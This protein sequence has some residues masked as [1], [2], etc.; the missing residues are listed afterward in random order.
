[1]ISET[2]VQEA[3]QAIAGAAPHVV[4]SVPEL[5]DVMSNT[6]SRIRNNADGKGISED[7]NMLAH[8][9]QPIAEFLSLVVAGAGLDEA[10]R[11]T[12]LW[13]V[14]SATVS[15]TKLAS[16]FSA[17]TDS[18]EVWEDMMA[19]L[20]NVEQD[21]LKL[22]WP[23]LSYWKVLGYLLVLAALSGAGTQL[24]SAG[25]S[26]FW[27]LLICTL[28]L[29]SAIVWSINGYNVG[30]HVRIGR[31]RRVQLPDRDPDAVS[32]ASSSLKRENEELRSKL[33]ASLAGQGVQGV[34]AAPPLP[35]PPGVPP[36][37]PGEHQAE[38][39]QAVKE[40]AELSVDAKPFEPKINVEAAQTVVDAPVVV[41]PAVGTEVMLGEIPTMPALNGAV[42]K[43][44][45][46]AGSDPADQKLQIT[47]RSGVVLRGVRPEIIVGLGPFENISAQSSE[48]VYAPY[49]GTPVTQLKAQAGRLR[50]ALVK[51]HGL[52]GSV[53][54]WASYFWQAVDNGNLVYGLATEIKQL[55]QVHGWVGK[56]TVAPPRFDELKKELLSFETCGGPSHGGA[57]RLLEEYGANNIAT[58]EFENPEQM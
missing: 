22:R 58:G 8:C 10:D 56:S 9:S 34:E 44:T 45:E 39:N 16:K 4:L 18:E 6:R 47:L 52:E 42:G 21:E 25:R 43:V 49:A 19:I 46:V 40:N 1:M 14:Y 3:Q 27:C 36:L 50:E 17:V 26:H 54:S 30:G 24:V 11:S 55:M 41:C 2:A 12:L 29:A 23:W 33:E 15:R 53:S 35:P 48:Q 38:Q 51:A 5:K 13:N 37:P 20:R 28:A 57:A 7:T 32:S 31:P